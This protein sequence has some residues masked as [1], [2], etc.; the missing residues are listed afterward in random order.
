M[1]YCPGGDL[2]SVLQNIGTFPEDKALLYTA[3]VVEALEFLR[4][5]NVIHRDLKPDNILVARNGHLKLT[6]FGMS[7]F[8]IFDRSVTSSDQTASQGTSSSSSE[9]ES[10]NSVERRDS[11]DSI[12]NGYS[13][14]VSLPG[15]P[16]Y[17]APEIILQQPHTFTADYWSLGCIIYEL[18]TGIPPFHGDTP[19]T[20]FANV[21]KGVY[22][23]AL[24]LSYDVSDEAVDLIR[25][26]LTRDPKK[27]LGSKS[28]NEIKQHPWFSNQGIDWNH[29]L[30]MEPPFVPQLENEEDTSYFEERYAMSNDDEKDIREDIELAKVEIANKRNEK[31]TESFFND[32]K[33][34]LF[35]ESTPTPP[36]ANQ[37]KN[38]K[39]ASLATTPEKQTTSNNTT[40]NQ[41]EETAHFSTPTNSTENASTSNKNQ[42]K[43]N[44]QQKT[45]N[46]NEIVQTGGLNITPKGPMSQPTLSRTSSN[47]S[48]NNNIGNYHTNSDDELSLFPSLSSGSLQTLTIED[49]MKKFQKLQDEAS[50]N[51][52]SS[53]LSPKIRVSRSSHNIHR[54]ILNEM[55]KE[56]LHSRQLGRNSPDLK[57][58]HSQNVEDKQLSLLDSGSPCN[59]SISARSRR[60]IHSKFHSSTNLSSYSNN[61]D[62]YSDEISQS[63]HFVESK[64]VSSFQDKLCMTPENGTKKKR[65]HSHR[66]SHRSASNKNSDEGLYS[67]SSSNLLSLLHDDNVDSHVNNG[68]IN[69]VNDSALINDNYSNSESNSPSVKNN[70]NVKNEYPLSK[71]VKSDLDDDESE[72]EDV[73]I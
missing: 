12:K 72:D 16:D 39:Q 9:Q 22:D 62:E 19:E 36:L 50:S 46:N 47:M 49:S 26:L 73:D 27:R 69:N 64:S 15:T 70:K 48:A 60:R 20:T 37:N 2:Y 55:R 40:A 53:E 68:E 71:Y 33:Q 61:Y 11:H 29:L 41:N 31:K 38:S 66:R 30:D 43:D 42:N 57:H 17:I 25:K 67:S 7:A 65:R 24:L 54:M 18:L 28:I 4:K 8:G 5:K 45:K 56:K 52:D 58:T 32:K 59:S 1:E 34:N 3:E 6:D 35:S 51:E 14:T 21:V 23:E 10:I 44:Q 63:P 13:S